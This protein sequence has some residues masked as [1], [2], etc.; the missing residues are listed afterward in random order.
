MNPYVDVALRFHYFFTRKVMFV[1]Y[2]SGFVVLPGGFGTLDELFEALDAHPDRA[3]RAH[4][5]VVLV[6]SEYW[7]GLVDWVRERLLAEGMIVA[8]TTS[9]CSRSPTTR[10]RSSSCL[11]PGAAAQGLAG[12]VA[13]R[14]TRRCTRQPVGQRGVGDLQH[15]LG[16]HLARSGRG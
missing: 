13:R 3:R 12:R 9:S 7:A 4:F 6:G 15:V 16:V 2:A 11:S 10:P 1:R 8:A 5:P 14:A